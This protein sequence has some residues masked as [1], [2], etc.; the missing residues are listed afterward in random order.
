MMKN[1]LKNNY[2]IYLLKAIPLLPIIYFQGKK[3]KKNIPLL[4]EAKNPEGFVDISANR[5]LKVLFIGESSFA[6]VGSVY[7]KDSFAGHFTTALSKEYS[8]NV[9][10]KVYAKTGYNV[11]QIQRKILPQIIEENCDLLVLG[12]GANDT[13][14]LT[15]PKNWTRSIQTLIRHLKTQFP[16]TPILFVQLPTIE[17]FPAFTKQMQSVLG[18]YKDLLAHHLNNEVLKNENVFYPNQKINVDEWL[19]KITKNQTIADFFSDGIHPSELT[20]QLWSEDSVK[21]LKTTE[22]RFN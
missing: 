17:S 5:N 3:I 12:I 7:H 16:S 1:R 11:E 20:Y 4:P 15:R 10:W 22:V 18:N 19:T 13:F 21:Y 9:D 2:F 6:G 8:S 14:E